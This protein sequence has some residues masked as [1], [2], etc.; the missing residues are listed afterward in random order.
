MSAYGYT[1]LES[2]NL[3]ATVAPQDNI[4]FLDGIYRVWSGY[5]PHIDFE[6][7]LGAFNFFGPALFGAW[8]DSPEMAL[9]LF[10]VTV[11]IFMLLSATWVCYSR[12]GIVSSVLFILYVAAIAGAPMNVGT[13]PESISH[14]MLYNRFGWAAVMIVALM[15]IPSRYSRLG[16]ITDTILLAMMA[17]L[18]LYLKVSYFLVII[19]LL[20]TFA[21]YNRFFRWVI[22]AA[23]AFSGTCAV[24]LSSLYP[25]INQ[26][27]ISNLTVVAGLSSKINLMKPVSK[28]IFEILPV[29]LMLLTTHIFVKGSGL[30]RFNQAFWVPL[31]MLVASLMIIENN[32][33]SYGLPLLFSALI[34]QIYFY[35]KTAE[36]NHEGGLS[37]F[38]KVLFL[39]LLIAL[40]LP[41]TFYR[42]ATLERYQRLSNTEYPAAID[43]SLNRFLIIPGK[44]DKYRIDLTAMEEESRQ[45]ILDGMAENTPTSAKLFKHQ[46]AL[47]ISEGLGHLRQ[48]MQQFGEGPVVSFDFSNPFSW[49]LNVEP[50]KNDYLWYHP[51][52][53]I[54]EDVHRP[55]SEFLADA[56]FVMS[57]KYPM[58]KRS[59]VLMESIAAGYLSH[60]FTKMDYD[61]WT[62]W[63]RKPLP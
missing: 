32:A 29:L 48:L 50:P 33:Q 42:Q 49:L 3:M 15:V 47:T 18:M 11:V 59:P 37:N 53:N 14:N 23:L 44:Q 38:E 28:N 9:L 43:S 17:A 25:G 27:Y 8:T 34:V 31:G 40:S 45:S 21:V 26:G 2:G 55:A 24:L 56:K 6:S 46:Q 39:S 61:Y 58:D 13:G 62:I 63:V 54:T 4:I 22:V 57:P 30:K 60:H 20:V 10:N 51:G 41:V 36:S 1:L 7:A 16:S 35:K 19:G 52:R 5:V 12:L